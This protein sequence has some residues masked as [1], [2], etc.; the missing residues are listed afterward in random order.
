MRT[1][2]LPTKGLGQSLGHRKHSADVTYDYFGGKLFT[3]Q[4]LAMHKAS[5]TG[6]RRRNMRIPIGYLLTEPS[7]KALPHK[8]FSSIIFWSLRSLATW[9]FHYAN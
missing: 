2:L 9:W 5:S 3:S 1:E 8:A 7:P 4:L 6:Q